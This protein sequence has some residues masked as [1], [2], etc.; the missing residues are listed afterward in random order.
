ML[1][2]YVPI[3]YRPESICI[4]ETNGLTM[5]RE[6]A[7]FSMRLLESY[8]CALWAVSE[9]SQC[10]GTRC[11]RLFV[12]LKGQNLQVEVKPW[13]LQEIEAPRILRQSAHEGGTVLLV[14][15]IVRL[16]HQGIFLVLFLSSWV[17][18]RALVRPE[19]LSQWKISKDRI[20]NRT[21]DL[22]TCSP[23][24]WPA[25]LPR[26]PLWR[27]IEYIWTGLIMLMTECVLFLLR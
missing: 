18:P 21:R 26:T 6:V 10:S 23:V 20:R 15:G 25:A 8:K 4:V 7:L 3:S 22:P 11:I 9:V 27:G 14:L 1:S 12:C 19:R 16:Y 2:K 5:S 13:G 17:D 24:P